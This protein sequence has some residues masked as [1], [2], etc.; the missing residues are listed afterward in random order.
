M[1]S[2]TDIYYIKCGINTQVHQLFCGCTDTFDQKLADHDAFSALFDSF[3]S[4]LVT[5]YVSSRRKDHVIKSCNVIRLQYICS[6]NNFC[7]GVLP[8]PR[9]RV[10]SRA[11]RLIMHIYTACSCI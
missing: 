5:K 6:Q 9:F 8:D 7:I 2:E 4:T 10:G 1:V 3:S 11:A